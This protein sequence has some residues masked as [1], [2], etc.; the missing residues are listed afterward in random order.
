[1][2]PEPEWTLRK[3]E[4]SSFDVLSV[5]LLEIQ[6][7]CDMMQCGRCISGPCYEGTTVFRNVAKYS[8]NN[9]VARVRKSD[10]PRGKFLLLPRKIS[11]FLGLPELTP[12][13]SE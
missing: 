13:T 8:P 12:V 4:N 7:F 3:R 1:V 5:V 2:L 11:L 9:T 6:V 10:S